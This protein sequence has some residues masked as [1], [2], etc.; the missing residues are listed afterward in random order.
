MRPHET[1]NYVHLP[2]DAE[3][4]S[5]HVGDMLTDALIYPDYPK[6][7]KVKCMMLDEYGWSVSQEDTNCQWFDPKFLRHYEPLVENVLADFACQV[8]NSGHQWGI[9]G[10]A[11]IAKYAKKLSVAEESDG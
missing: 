1:E 4:K 9:D 11:V 10:P 7:R 8:I 3:G 2:K 5:I 6:P